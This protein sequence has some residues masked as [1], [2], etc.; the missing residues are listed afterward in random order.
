MVE[1]P[2]PNQNLL[3]KYVSILTYLEV[4]LVSYN[5]ICYTCIEVKVLSQTVFTMFYIFMCSYLLLLH[6]EMK[7]LSFS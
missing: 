4:W 2:I 5:F 6:N 3:L 1:F 7:Y